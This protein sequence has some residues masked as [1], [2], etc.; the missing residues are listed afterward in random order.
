MIGSVGSATLAYGLGPMMVYG[1]T[2]AR[3]GFTQIAAAIVQ[4]KES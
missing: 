2:G 3:P 4:H 1:A